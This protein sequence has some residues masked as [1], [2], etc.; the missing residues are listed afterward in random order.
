LQLTEHEDQWSVLN[1]KD[2]LWW[3]L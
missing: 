2:H 3:L 1:T